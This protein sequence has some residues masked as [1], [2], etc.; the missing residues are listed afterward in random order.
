MAGSISKLLKVVPAITPLN[1]ILSLV[2]RD[3]INALYSSVLVVMFIKAPTV[4]LPHNPRSTL[5]SV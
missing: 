4:F 2:F 1:V 5:D 3:S